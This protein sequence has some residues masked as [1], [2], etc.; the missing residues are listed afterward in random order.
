VINDGST[1][2]TEKV[3]RPYR[4][5]IKYLEKQNEGKPSA[6][7]AGLEHVTGDYV[8]IVDDDDV[9]ISDAWESHSRVLEARAELGFTYGPHYVAN[10]GEDG[11]PVE[12]AQ[13]HTPP[14]SRE[15]EL[16]LRLMERSFF[17]GASAFVRT[18][19]YKALGGLDPSLIRSQDLEFILRLWR[20]FRG[21]RVDHPI[22]YKRIHEGLRGPAKYRWTADQS[23]VVWRDYNV[24]I[25]TKLRTELSLSDYLP[26]SADGQPPAIIDQRFAYLQRMTIMISR[27]MYDE[28]L[29][30]LRLAM[31]HATD[32]RAL[33]QAERAMLKRAASYPWPGDAFFE[34]F[35]YSRRIRALCAGQVGREIRLVLGRGL[36]WRAANATRSKN[37]TFARKAIAAAFRLLGLWGLLENFPRA[38]A[39]Y[40]R[41]WHAGAVRLRSFARTAP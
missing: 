5:R 10:L 38:I 25:F 14:D 18:S 41:A 7:N 19:C 24:K 23:K 27:G 2:D 30:D 35:K 26:R 12:P 20:R 28:M 8:W 1:D 21:A 3:L 17:G 34:Q 15:G 40:A 29:E 13:L 4:H 32:N 9:M 6:V 36:L 22:F 16:F 39:S 31:E 33:S 11:K 37:Y